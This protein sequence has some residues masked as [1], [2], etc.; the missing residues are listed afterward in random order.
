MQ[1]KLPSFTSK[2]LALTI[3]GI[4]SIFCGKHISS[5]LKIWGNLYFFKCFILTVILMYVDL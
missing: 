5:D 3:K 2:K 4:H 1:R